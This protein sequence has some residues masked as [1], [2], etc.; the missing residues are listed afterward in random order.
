[1]SDVTVGL[2]QTFIEKVGFPIVVCAGIGWAYYTTVGWERDT[3]IPA[4]KENTA[5]LVV[6]AE[7]AKE[8]RSALDREAKLT[9]E[10][11]D[12]VTTHSREIM[13]LQKKSQN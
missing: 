4:I 10:I 8:V 13:E 2:V 3:M 7:V 1:M 9:A 12:Q 5:A 11:S 6:N